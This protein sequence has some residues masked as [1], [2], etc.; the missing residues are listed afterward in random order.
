MSYEYKDRK[1]VCIVSDNLETWQAM[2]IVGHLAVGLGANK[3]SELMGRSALKD[4]SNINHLGIARYGFIIKK[5]TST[6]IREAVEASRQ[7]KN[8]IALDFPREMLDTSHDDELS[9]WISKK[10]EK[11]FEYLGAI[12]YGPSNEIIPLTKKFPL[13]S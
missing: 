9:G 2:N 10:E 3:D 7:I 11:N 6:A 12:F 5:G 13:W 4:A 8:I 1:I